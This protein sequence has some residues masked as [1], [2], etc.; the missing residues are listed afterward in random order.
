MRE[1]A[2]GFAVFQSMSAFAMTGGVTIST[3][4][5]P[6]AVYITAMTAQCSGTLISPHFIVTAAHCLEKVQAHPSFVRL[7]RVYSTHKKSMEI[8]RYFIH[9]TEDLALLELTQASEVQPAVLTSPHSEANDC[10]VVGYGIPYNANG[11][12]L[13]NLDGKATDQKR[14]GRIKLSSKKDQ[15]LKT[16]PTEFWARRLFPVSGKK[17]A[18]QITMGDSGGP[19]FCSG[20]LSGVSIQS[21]VS[22]WLVGEGRFFKS[23]SFFLDLSIPEINEWIQEQAKL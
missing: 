6:E 20:Q 4:T 18:V 17:A 9:P 1:L 13:E 5:H 7:I 21:I 8:S 22:Y 14:I 16:K 11:L 19:L 2:I 15:Y 23:Q 12:Y 3:T 10:S